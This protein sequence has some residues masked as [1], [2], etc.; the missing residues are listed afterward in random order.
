[1]SKM[2]KMIVAPVLG[3]VLALS[4]VGCGTTPAKPEEPAPPAADE[5]NQQV[6]TVV[7]YNEATTP[8]YDVVFRD[9]KAAVDG[10][11]DEDV[12]KDVPAIAGGFHFPWDPKEAPFTEFKGYNDGTDFYFSFHV[13]DAEVLADEWTDESTVDNEDRV[14]LFFAGQYIDKPS[15]EGMKLYYGIEV[16]PEGRVHDY[17]IKYYR[18]FDTEWNLEGLETAAVTTENGYDVEGKIPLK[19][20]EDLELINNGVMRA[21]VYRAEFS[22]TENAEEPILME[23]ISWVDPKTAV[24]DYHVASSFGEFR[25]LER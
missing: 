9:G 15:P 20:L 8:H 19:S 23:W 21:G 4:V 1:M 6:T 12:W 16:D 24:P 13:V 14:E 7:A 17:S 5:T 10:V 18:D 22:S 11:L 3:A 25:F 2:S